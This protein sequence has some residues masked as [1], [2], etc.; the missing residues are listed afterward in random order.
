MTC[1][2]LAGSPSPALRVNFIDRQQAHTKLPGADSW[3]SYDVELCMVTIRNMSIE[4]LTVHSSLCANAG[5]GERIQSLDS[6]VGV[7]RVC[8]CCRS[9]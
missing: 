3:C 5:I 8:R 1:P 6:D 2:C 4:V 9:R 7:R